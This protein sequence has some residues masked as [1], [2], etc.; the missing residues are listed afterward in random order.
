VI[1]HYAFSKAEIKK[2]DIF[3]ILD[4]VHANELE[5]KELQLLIEKEVSKLPSRMQEI[6][7][8]SR[9]DDYS[10]A[11]IAKRLNISEQTVKNQLT[12]ALKRL[13]ASLQSRMSGG[14]ALV[15]FYLFCHFHN[16]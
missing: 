2:V 10:I 12:E 14:W 3:D 7:R 6:F 8:M 4:E 9:E 16:K 11:E 13:R 5:T 1:S 15:L